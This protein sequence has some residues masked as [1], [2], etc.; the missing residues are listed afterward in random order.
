SEDDLAQVLARQGKQTEAD[1]E[2]ENAIAEST[3]GIELKPDAW[4]SWSCRAFIHLHWQQCDKAIP[5]FSK[6]IELAPQVHM[7]WWHRGHCYLHLAQWDKAAADFGKVIEQWPEGG[8]GWCWH[9]VALAQLNQPEKAM[10]DL[11]EAARK[12]FTGAEWM[13]NES[14]LDPVRAREDF[15]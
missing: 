8:E 12:G 9:A 14:R 10:A 3:K 6:A 11:R 7:L 1:A 2:R 5:D 4:E 13:K 15:R